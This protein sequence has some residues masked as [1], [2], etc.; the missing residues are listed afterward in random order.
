MKTYQDYLKVK[1]Q[2]SEKELTT[3]VR[4]VIEDYKNSDM[5]ETAVL[6]DEYDRHQ[7]R[8][9][10]EYQKVLYTLSGNTVPDNFSANYK[11]ISGHF[12][13]VVSQENQFLLG[14]GVTWNNK[15]EVEKKLGDDFD[16]VLQSIG[17][18]AL[19]HGV[20]YGFFNKDHVNVFKALE[21]A[22][23]LDETNGAVCAGVRFWQIDSTK[24]LR[25]TLY[26][27]DGYTEYIWRQGKEGEILKPKTSYIVFTATTA[28]DGTTI[29][30]GENYPSFPIIPCYAN[31]HHQSELI[32]RQEQIDSYDLIKSGFA[33]DLD[34]AS[35]IYWTMQ[36]A[37]GMNDADLALFMQRMKTVHAALLEADGATAEAHT[38]EVPYNAREAI[39]DRLDKDLYRD[40]MALNPSDIASG[41]ITATQI[42][43]SFEP[44]NMKTNGFE[45]C[46]LEFLSALCEVAGIQNEDPTF[47][48]GM[49]VNAQEEV[50]VVLSAALYLPQEYVTRK[51]LTI[52]GDGDK[53]D[54][55]I[56]QMNAEDMERLT[57]GAEANQPEENE[58]A[59]ETE[60]G[61]PIEE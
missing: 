6:A 52:L 17:E 43:A 58:A 19:I 39:L 15:D 49:L 45:Y 18:F 11:L 44:L 60:G 33:D 16:N 37:G 48:R 42:K 32:G 9:I 38:M 47:Q 56:E 2:G 35:Q 61:L 40:F 5:Y 13:Y 12:P 1:E 24:P 10:R 34:D 57:T 54:E 23:L 3:F 21:F 29:Y 8:T 4:G 53:A 36:N 27:E 20:S 50:Q 51:I 26:E 46:I 25:A 28:I 31:R 22:P 55:I 7:N 41:A 59:Q 14:N 30:D